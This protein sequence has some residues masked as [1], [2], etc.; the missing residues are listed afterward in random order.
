MLHVDVLLARNAAMGPF[1]RVLCARTYSSRSK[2]PSS[3]KTLSGSEVR[4]EV[5]CRHKK[6][7]EM[8]RPSTSRTIRIYASWLMNKTPACVFG[9]TNA[10]NKATMK[11]PGISREAIRST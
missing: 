3:W 8:T 7:P 11:T 1:T 5:S 9:T 10:S 6:R 4:R 2:V